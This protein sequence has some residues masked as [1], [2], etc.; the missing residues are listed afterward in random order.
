[1]S[2]LL[3]TWPPFKCDMLLKRIPDLCSIQNMH[4]T[5]TRCMLKILAIEHINVV[6]GILSLSLSLSSKG[7]LPLISSVDQV[8]GPYKF[9]PGKGIITFCRDH[10]NFGHLLYCLLHGRPLIILG[11]P[12]DKE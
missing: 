1:M 6:H 3:P 8:E 7:K 10:P 4:N 12:S 5:D 9:K 2:Y 11:K